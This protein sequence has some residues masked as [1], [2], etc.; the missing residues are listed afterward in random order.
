MTTKEELHKMI[1]TLDE[2]QLD[3]AKDVLRKVLQGKSVQAVPVCDLGSME[4]VASLYEGIVFEKNNK[5]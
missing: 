3:H 2:K 1:D 5:S 4:D